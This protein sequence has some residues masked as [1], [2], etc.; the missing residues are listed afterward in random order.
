M[1]YNHK[2]MLK[3]YFKIAW[4]NLSRNRSHAF[5]NL[6]GLAIGIACCLLIMLWVVDELSYDKWYE[7]SSRIYRPVVEIK[8]GGAHR[9]F[10]VA[11][12]PMAGALMSDFPEIETAVRF[13][14]IGSVIVSKDAERS[15]KEEVVFADSTLLD[16][17]SFKLLKGNPK[18]ALAAPNTVVITEAIARKYFPNDEA[19]GQKL[20]LDGEM[21]LT[22]TGVIEDIPHN[23]HFDYP[24]YIS[25]TSQE[26]GQNQIWVSNNFNTYY[27]LR[28]GVDAQAFEAKVYPYFMKTYVAPQVEQ[29]LGQ[30]I[31][32]LE[33]SGSFIRYTSQPLEDIHL[34]SDLEVEM[35]VNG[36][37]QYVWLFSIAA[38][39]I[40][41]IACVNFMNLSTARSAL[42]AKE[43]GVRK[44]LGSI[45]SNLISQFLVEAMLMT[46]LAFVLGLLLSFL[47]LPY[48]ND[49]ADKQLYLP[50]NQVLFWTVLLGGIFLVGLLAGSYP[51][52]YLS[53]FKPIK[54]L[55]GKIREK[56][57]NLNLRNSLV[58]FQFLVAV[59]M[60]IG[61]L[62]IKEQ[63]DFIQNKKLGFEKEQVLII[64]NCEPLR[65]RVFTLKD[66]L[67]K[68]PRI[69]EATVSGFLPV[70]SYRTD[71]PMAK[72]SIMREDNSVSMQMWQIDETYLSV[73]GME[74]VAGRNFSPDMP[75][76]SNAVILNETAVKLFGFDDPIGKTVYGTTNFNANANE[77]LPAKT[78]IGV[79]K[80]F[81]F[82]SLRDNIG[83]LS[84][85]L[86]PY[87]GSLSMKVQTSDISTLINEIETDWKSI[88]PGLPFDYQFLDDSFESIYRSE[89][90]IS[91]IFAIF[92]GLSVLVACLGLF[93]LATFTVERR[94]KE[95]GVRKVLGASTTSLIGL[96][97]KDF[98]KLVLIALVIAIPGAWYFARHWLADYAYRIDLSW[99]TFAIAGVLA[100]AIAFVTVSFQSI[101]AAM[102]NP[103]D[104]LRNE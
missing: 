69:T 82:E 52:F 86:D 33:K 72:E 43:I 22:V 74:L 61:T 15:G 28:E 93:G 36:S 8:F 45:R 37:I 49:L 9:N 13:R 47:A 89:G 87:P 35:G 7:K 62:V 88:A 53:A 75:T 6:I 83:A 97:S 51:A 31:E 96:L 57:G 18:T 65:D 92:S 17:F 91:Q 16:V 78:I 48:F 25:M 26:E 71:S 21:E 55:S 50:Y 68:N 58:V 99:S 27:V 20:E 12:A 63:L 41:V 46:A 5:I 79:V 1:Y 80:D 64:Q 2:T 42:R 24:I 94:V 77:P 34:N 56:G 38:L 23:S 11:P 39:F 84:F 73:F 76:D 85:W 29:F 67:L 40:L 14:Q 54:T 19:M 104:S 60:I 102:A 59:F 95:I 66:Q 100:I 70:P 81:H 103:V 90:R 30:S 4:R 44:V 32:E 98:L 3:N 101:K 10:A